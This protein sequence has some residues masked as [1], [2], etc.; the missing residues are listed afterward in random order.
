MFAIQVPDISVK[1]CPSPL[2]DVLPKKYKYGPELTGQMLASSLAFAIE[3]PDK[4]KDDNAM[5]QAGLEG[6]LRAYEAIV[7]QE[8]KGRVDKVDELIKARDS[9]GLAEYVKTVAAKSCKS[10]K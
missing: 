3:H 7:K 10:D 2:Y 6:A 8:P 1:I 4:A 5:Y 9:A